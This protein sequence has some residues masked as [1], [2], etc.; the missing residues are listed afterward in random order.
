MYWDAAA[1][2]A[3]SAEKTRSTHPLG[4]LAGWLYPIIMWQRILQGTSQT[5]VPAV[6]VLGDGEKDDNR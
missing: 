5:D 6:Y 3:A 4:W 2:A 1:A